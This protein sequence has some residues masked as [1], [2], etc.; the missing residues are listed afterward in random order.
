[1]KPYM[2]GFRL[3]L[4]L[5]ALVSVFRMVEMYYSPSTVVKIRVLHSWV[6]DMGV[7]ILFMIPIVALRQRLK[8]FFDKR[9]TQGN[10]SGA[11]DPYLTIGMPLA[12]TIGLWVVILLFSPISSPVSHLQLAYSSC[13]FFSILAFS[14]L[15]IPF[16][17]WCGERYMSVMDF[18]DGKITSF[19]TTPWKWL[20]RWIIS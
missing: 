5:V 15:A 10:E 9:N 11:L 4:V 16:L 13:F 2:I 19:I 6:N 20:Y 14:Y 8:V 17:Y 7:M 3:S 1:M 12:I 18:I